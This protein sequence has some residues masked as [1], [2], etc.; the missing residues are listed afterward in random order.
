MLLNGNWIMIEAEEFN[1]EYHQRVEDNVNVLVLFNQHLAASCR[2]MG[3]ISIIDTK[4]WSFF[5]FSMTMLLLCV[6]TCEIVS[7]V[8]CTRCSVHHHQRWQRYTAPKGTPTGSLLLGGVATLHAGQPPSL[9]SPK[10]IIYL[11][12]SIYLFILL[13]I[14]IKAIFFFNFFFFFWKKLNSD[15]FWSKKPHFFT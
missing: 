14:I 5:R 6:R 13:L 4:E 1:D 8:L 3:T 2:A 12:I 10:Y 7:A 15:W 9:P 11:N